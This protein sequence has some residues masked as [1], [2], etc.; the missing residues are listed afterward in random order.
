MYFSF[1]SDMIFFMI[2]AGA[3][4]G[5]LCKG[6]LINANFPEVLNETYACSAGTKLAV[7]IRF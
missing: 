7:Y 5:M 2:F 4:E 3:A 1:S 6:Y